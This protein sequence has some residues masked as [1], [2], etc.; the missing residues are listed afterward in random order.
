[1]WKEQ[2]SSELNYVQMI[3]EEVGKRVLD[4]TVRESMVNNASWQGVPTVD[5][6]I[7]VEM[8]V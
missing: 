2:G 1:M 3:P 5:N 7:K 6:S 4:R 8:M